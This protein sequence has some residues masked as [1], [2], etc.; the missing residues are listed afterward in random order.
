MPRDKYTGGYET[1]RERRGKGSWRL[2]K[3]SILCYKGRSWTVA[4]Q[5]VVQRRY[6]PQR[7]STDRPIDRSTDRPT[8]LR[9]HRRRRVSSVHT[10]KSYF[11]YGIKYQSVR[12][13][14]FGIKI[15]A[16]YVFFFFFCQIFDEDFVWI[17]LILS[18]TVLIYSRVAVKSTGQIRL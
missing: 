11:I 16:A 10:T 14:P 15:I 1:G 5:T 4:D 18:F 6:E 8:P 17:N 3:I 2:N 12:D 13:C 7:G 9:S